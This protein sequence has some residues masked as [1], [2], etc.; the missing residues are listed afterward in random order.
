M[1]VQRH[2]KA[3]FPGMEGYDESK[4]NSH[5]VYLDA[6]NLYGVPMSGSLPKGKFKWETGISL[7]DIM[8]MSDSDS[9]GCFVEVDLSVPEECHDWLNEYPLAPELK[10]VTDSMLSPYCR[11]LQVGVDK[12]GKEV[13]VIGEDKVRKLMCT[14]EPKKKYVCHYKNLQ[15]YLALGMNVDRIHR[16][17]SFEQ[18]PWMAAYIAMNTD[19]RKHAK[20]EFEKDLFKLMNNAVFGKTMENVRNHINFKLV[21]TK[22]KLLRYTRMPQCNQEP[23]R[24]SDNLVGFNMLKKEVVL[25][26][27]VYVGAA[28]LDISKVHMYKFHYGYIKV[29]YGDKARLLFTD[30]D[31]LTYHIETEDVYAD[32]KQDIQHFDCSGYDVDHPLHDKTNAKVIGKFKDETEGVRITEF[33]GLKPKMYA[34]TME[35][36]KCKKTAKGVSRPVVKTLG[37]DD[38]KGV[39]FSRKAIK[40]DMHAIRSFKHELYTIKVNKVALNAYCNKRYWREDGVNAYA[41]GHKNIGQE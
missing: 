30:T 20:N 34:F 35:D 7:V 8:K 27:P 18:S 33:V 31:S 29:K 15:L 17:L 2:A 22:E 16:V 24:F 39:L 19:L 14:L 9:C 23:I 13:R 4:P 32:M 41:Y 28:I 5:I 26:K 25:D 6:N 10:V 3:N 11:A 37:F 38:Y 12:E 21:T 36:G 40:R 1:I